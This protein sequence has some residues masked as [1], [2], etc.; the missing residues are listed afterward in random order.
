MTER[1]GVFSALLVLSVCVAFAPCFTGS[2]L[3]YDDPWLIVDN[4]MFAP[5]AEGTLQA[6]FFDLS[7]ETRFALGASRATRSARW[8]L[9]KSRR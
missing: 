8:A 2:F 3:S 5:D 1:G 4:P 6:A 9:R 7:F